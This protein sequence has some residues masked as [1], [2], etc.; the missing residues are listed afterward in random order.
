MGCHVWW[1]GWRARAGSPLCV[2]MPGTVI[3]SL[4]IDNKLKF[5]SILPKPINQLFFC[6]QQCYCQGC[7]KAEI[8][9]C[10]D[11]GIDGILTTLSQRKGLL[12]ASLQCYSFNVS[13]S[14]LPSCPPSRIFSVNFRYRSW[15][16]ALLW[17]Y[18]SPLFLLRY[19]IAWTGDLSQK[20]IPTFTCP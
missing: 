14:S 15:K 3:R 12:C 18:I 19:F 11:V 7:L 6:L 8:G 10:L 20:P 9:F 16:T 1:W 2:P 4:L 5:I 13:L 17:C